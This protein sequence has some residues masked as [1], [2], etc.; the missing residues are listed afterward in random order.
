MRGCQRK[1]RFGGVECLWLAVIAD[2]R[3][4]RVA[5]GGEGHDIKS[6]DPF[7]G[8]CRSHRSNG[9]VPVHVGDRNRGGT[10]ELRHVQ[11][12]AVCGGTERLRH[13][14]PRHETSRIRTVTE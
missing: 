13:P 7:C 8:E 2:A 3:A 9:W 10:S 11:E 1:R 5:A 4:Y 14:A 12:C 6:G